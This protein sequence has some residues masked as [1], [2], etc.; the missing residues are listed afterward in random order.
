MSRDRPELSPETRH[1]RGHRS[2]V[3]RHRADMSRNRPTTLP[4]QL[5][6]SAPKGEAIGGKVEGGDVDVERSEC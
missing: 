6:D 4:T 2:D 5:L 3:S 1:C